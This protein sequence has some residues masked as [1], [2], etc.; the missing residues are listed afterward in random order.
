MGSNRTVSAIDRHVS[1]KLKAAR[2]EKGVSQLD[3]AAALGVTFQQIQ[4]YEN[5]MDRIAAGRLYELAVYYGKPIGWF[6]PKPKG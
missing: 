4:K 2:L 1:S 6:F 5:E 3:A